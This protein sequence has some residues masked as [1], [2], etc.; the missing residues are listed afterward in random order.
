MNAPLSVDL[1]PGL[2]GSIFDG[3]Q[4]PLVKI[5]EKTGNNLIRGVEVPALD[6]EKKWTFVPTAKVGDAVAP[7]DILGTV[8]E[9]PVVEQRIMVP[10]GVSGKIISLQSGVFTIEET[11]A[12]VE[13]AEENRKKS[14]CCRN[15]LS[16]WVALIK[17]T[18]SYNAFDYRTSN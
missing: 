6:M 15:G 14:P 8:R 7:C 11:I 9:T 2:I 3:I 5:M 17:K 1:A 10:H 13:T 16:V 18:C 12:V 4:R